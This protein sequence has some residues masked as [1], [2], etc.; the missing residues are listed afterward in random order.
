[1]P[2]SFS[3]LA[4]ALLVSPLARAGILDNGDLDGFER[5]AAY[6]G[7]FAL[8]IQPQVDCPA[9]SVSCSETDSTGGPCCPASTFCATTGNYCCTSCKSVGAWPGPLLVSTAAGLGHLA[10]TLIAADCSSQIMANPTCADPSW[11]LFTAGQL[12]VGLVEGI[13]CPVGMVVDIGLE[14]ATPG[15]SGVVSAV[16]TAIATG[17]T[18]VS[19]LPT[20]TRVK[21]DGKLENSTSN[22][23]HRQARQTMPSR[24]QGLY[25]RL[26][27]PVRLLPRVVRPEHP[28]PQPA[29]LLQAAPLLRRLHHPRQL[30]PRSPTVIHSRRQVDLWAGP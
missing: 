10:N 19:P 4:L 2:P 24:R 29:V 1:M 11:V 22:H 30:L 8:G 21:L 12:G 28:P 25:P 14:C 23:W 5:R 26:L 17:Y 3:L 9:G 6:Y 20:M 15:G 27:P 18:T 7:G 16:V 13:C